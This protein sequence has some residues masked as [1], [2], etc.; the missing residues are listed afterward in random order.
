[1]A[2]AKSWMMIASLEPQ[3]SRVCK[4]KEQPEGEKDSKGN[5]DN[6]KCK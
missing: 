4:Q 1:M 6:K 3:K 5:G 2:Q